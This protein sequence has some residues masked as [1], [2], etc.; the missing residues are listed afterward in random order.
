MKRYVNRGAKGIALIDTSSNNSRLHYVF[1]I[2]DT[3]GQRIPF[4]WQYKD[5]FNEQVVADIADSFN[6]DTDTLSFRR[7][8]RGYHRYYA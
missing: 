8:Y 5:E 7:N 1:D 4:I 2:S 3:N 6:L